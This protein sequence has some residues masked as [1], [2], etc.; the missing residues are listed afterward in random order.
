MKSM[1][2][3]EQEV[4]NELCRRFPEYKVETVQVNKTNGGY[5]AYVVRRDMCASP[6]FNIDWMYERVVKKGEEMNVVIDQILNAGKGT[7]LD[8][9]ANDLLDYGKVKDRL[10]IRIVNADWNRDMLGDIPWRPFENL[11]I[12]CYVDIDDEI[13]ARVTNK[14]LG[15]YNISEDELFETAIKNSSQRKNLFISPL[16]GL[17]GMGGGTGL[18][19]LSTEKMAY[20]ASAI[21]FPG[22]LEKAAEYVGGNIFVLPSSVH[23][24]LFLKDDGCMGADALLSI[25]KGVNSDEVA[26]DERLADNVY[27]YNREDKSFKIVA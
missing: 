2:T 17:L 21:A 12:I 8:M 4:F 26:E 23:E 5:K 13:C 9:A 25:V 11:A 10:S 7:V 22:A 27:Y 1:K 19:V 18:H 15:A 16:G 24:V 6:L 3:F 14:M 20:G